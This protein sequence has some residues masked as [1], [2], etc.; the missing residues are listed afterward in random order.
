MLL[1]RHFNPNS[2]SLIIKNFQK[3][4]KYKESHSLFDVKLS[5]Q[6]KILLN[7]KEGD[8]LCL[9]LQQ[10]LTFQYWI[11]RHYD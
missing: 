11:Y 10:I 2:F 5:Y 3:Y 4:L 7:K 8:S 6:T 9:I 1:S